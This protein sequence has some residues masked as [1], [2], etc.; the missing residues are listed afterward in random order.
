VRSANQLKIKAVALCQKWSEAPDIQHVIVFVD[1][2]YHL[3]GTSSRLEVT[4]NTNGFHYYF[5]V[6]GGSSIPAAT[7]IPNTQLITVKVV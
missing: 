6:G 7:K 3:V 2:N 4:G 1:L 5:G